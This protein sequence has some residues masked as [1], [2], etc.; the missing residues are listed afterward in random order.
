VL[1]SLEDLPD[2][3]TVLGSLVLQDL[4]G[5]SQHLF[6][7][8]SILG[9]EGGRGSES[10]LYVLS[11]VGEEEARIEHSALPPDVDDLLDIHL[12]ALDAPLLRLLVTVGSFL[13]SLRPDG[14]PE[15]RSHIYAH[16]S[17]LHLLAED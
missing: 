8:L 5:W 6:Q 3:L 7:S 4:L 9:L 10:G 16:L 2:L 15:G 1:R 14:G 12:E 11:M 13:D 17:I